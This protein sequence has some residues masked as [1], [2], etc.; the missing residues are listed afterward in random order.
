MT[1]AETAER[2]AALIRARAHGRC[3][4]FMPLGSLTS[5]QLGGPADVYIEAESEEDLAALADALDETGLPLLVIGRGSNMLVSDEGFPGIAVRLGGGFRWARVEGTAV[6]AGGA[7]P[8]PALASLAAGASLAGLEFAAAIPASFGGA[9]A[10][11]AGAH[12]RSISEV[13]IEATVFDLSA[14]SSRTIDAADLGFV[15]RAS[16]LPAGSIVTAG[17]AALG[18]GDPDE[19]AAGMREAREW[20]RATQ[21]VG[22]PNAGSVFKNPPEEAAGSLVERICGKGT[23]HGGARISE[24]HANFIVAEPG[25][26]AA[27]VHTLIRRIQRQVLENAGVRLETEVKLIGRFEESGE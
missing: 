18:P 9:I 19:I 22:L 26:T 6:A 21:P 23:T 12:H 16:A 3:E 5:Y 7:M 1:R 15:Y 27:D 4:T 25:A 14:R 2:A 8:V 10:M 17:L 24:V 13:L 11:N 20:R